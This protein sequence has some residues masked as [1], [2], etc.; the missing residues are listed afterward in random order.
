MKTQLRY[1]VCDEDG[2]LRKFATRTEATYFMRCREDLTL[3][4]DKKQKRLPEPVV[5]VY[6][7]G[8]AVF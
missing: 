8:E 3:L 5:N 2:T 6:D 4:V 7:F 1:R